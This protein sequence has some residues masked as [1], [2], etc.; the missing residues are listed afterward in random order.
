MTLIE[1]MIAV[2]VLAIAIVGLL[3]AMPVATQATRDAEQNEVARHAIE[4]QIALI[5]GAG[6]TW[7]D[8]QH[9]AAADGEAGHPF[10][11]DELENVLEGVACG[12]VSGQAGEDLT[13]RVTVSVNWRG[14]D[15]AER[16]VVVTT[17]VAS[18]QTW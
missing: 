17:L 15:G 1:I 4:N 16:E 7:E 11:V 9:H 8:W 3:T 2:A 18:D 14:I 10:P 12:L 13:R 6:D 5:R